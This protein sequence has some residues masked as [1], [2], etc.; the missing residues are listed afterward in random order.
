MIKISC[1]HYEESMSVTLKTVNKFHG[2][3]F[4]MSILW[5]IAFVK[6]VK[7]TKV[8]LIMSSLVISEVLLYK[9]LNWIKPK[10]NKKFSLQINC[11]L[12]KFLT[13]LDYLL[14]LYQG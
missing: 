12:I 10:E 1:G 6:Y 14:L 7:L 9:W 2:E 8:E 5:L 13:V 4:N 3:I 11:I